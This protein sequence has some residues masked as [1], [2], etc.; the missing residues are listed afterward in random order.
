MGFCSVGE[1]GYVYLGDMGPFGF[2]LSPSPE[3]IH[4]LSPALST[5]PQLA[6]RLSLLIHSLCT[7]EI[8][9]SYQGNSV[10]KTDRHG[11]C[12]PTAQYSQPLILTNLETSKLVNTDRSGNYPSCSII[13]L[14]L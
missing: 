14:G 9:Y 2:C 8:V 10:K 1:Y 11:G 5:Y 6:N 12:I 13:V 4:S 3:L 7:V